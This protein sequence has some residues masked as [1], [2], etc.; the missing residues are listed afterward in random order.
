MIDVVNDG[1]KQRDQEL[2]N[3]IFF[4]PVKSGNELIEKS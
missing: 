1:N 4:C 3:L 2:A